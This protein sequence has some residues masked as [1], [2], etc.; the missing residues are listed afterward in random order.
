[1]KIVTS[2]WYLV[3]GKTLLVL[4]LLVASFQLPVTSQAQ[5]ASP[6]ADLSAKLKALQDSIASKASQIKQ[7]IS[8]KL[9]NK[10]YVGKVIQKGNNS[11]TIT[12]KEKSH[13]VKVTQDTA[14]TNVARSLQKL[15]EGDYIAALG[16][17]DQDGNLM[18]KR[19]GKFPDGLD[20]DPTLIYGVVTNLDNHLF[21]ISSS[22][23]GS[24]ITVNVTSKTNFLMGEESASFFDLKVNK[25]VIVI[26]TKSEDS[27]KPRT[28]Y[29]LPYTASGK[30]KT[31][32]PTP[33][34]TPSAK[35]KK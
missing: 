1:M 14:Y 32:S 18:A 13:V 19:I 25:P 10:V 23:K 29:I 8:K 24:P 3:A 35:I 31:P 21:T 30:N 26:G 11:L 6:S 27:I 17:S 34:A 4:I 2:H 20:P 16:D 22:S 9:Q 12:F 7:T 15:S 28:V 33:A 5:E